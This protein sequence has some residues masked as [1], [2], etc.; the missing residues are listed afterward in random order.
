MARI[1]PFLRQA[2]HT[3]HC[4]SS[5]DLKKRERAWRP[6]P[7]SEATASCTA[8]DRAT[9]VRPEKRAELIRTEKCVSPASE[10]PEWPACCALSS[11]TSRSSGE[12]AAVSAACSRSCRVI[13]KIPVEDPTKGHPRTAGNDTNHTNSFGCATTRKSCAVRR[14]CSIRNSAIPSIAPCRGLP[15]LAPDAH[16]G[17]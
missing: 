16:K 12:N 14:Q 7:S 9:L 5:G 8:R 4:L 13:Q 17:G 2:L 10:A 11:I 1:I 3:A 6:L 15:H